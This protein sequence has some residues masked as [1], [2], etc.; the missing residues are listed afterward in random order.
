MSVQRGLAARCALG[1]IRVYQR[2][3]SPRKGFSCA[4]REATGGQGCSAYGY[5]VI[6]RCGLRVGMRLLRRRLAACGRQHRFGGGPLSYQ[7][8]DCD[9][10]C[11]IDL[12]DVSRTCCTGCDLGTWGN[13]DKKR[14]AKTA[15]FNALRDRV[16]K[17]KHK[18]ARKD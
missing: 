2:H 16:A 8:G 14:K 17:A 5:R 11:D 15:E 18:N 10:G 6:D 7:Q 13:S 3:L 9:P 4:L 12:G 1:A